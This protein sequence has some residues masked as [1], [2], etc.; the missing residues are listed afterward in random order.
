MFTFYSVNISSSS[1]LQH[2]VN[3]AKIPFGVRKYENRKKEFSLNDL[4][5]FSNK[6]L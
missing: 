4:I 2:L 1:S 3:A 6:N 5:D